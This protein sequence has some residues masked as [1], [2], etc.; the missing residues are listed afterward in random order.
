MTLLKTGLLLFCVLWLLPLGISALLYQRDGIG[1]GWRIADRSSAG[2]LPSPG[3]HQPAVVRVLAAQTVRWRG[4]FAVHC[5]IVFKPEGARA[6]TR[7]D[8]TAWG[9]PI[10]MNG[11]EPDGRW[12]GRVPEVV[13]AAD[14]PAAEAMIPRIE[15]AIRDYA[16]QNHGDYRAWPGP[17]SNTF[18]AA[19]LDAVPGIRV[20]LPPTAIGKDYPYDGRSIRLTPSGTGIRISLGGYAGLT[21]AWVEGVEVNIL[22]GVAGFDLR[23]PAIK[24]PGLGRLG[25]GGPDGPATPLPKTLDAT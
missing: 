14:G 15:A 10:R 2:I 20:S 21:L 25:M 4:I 1:A 3:Q 13:F 22:G 19:V 18:V 17:N 8:Y 24:L 11:F 6:Y 23:R 12:F 5:W 7:Y 16:W 9:E